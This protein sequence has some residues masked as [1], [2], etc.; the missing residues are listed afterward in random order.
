MQGSRVLSEP[1]NVRQAADLPESR[2]LKSEMR[3]AR[4]ESW[5]ALGPLTLLLI[6]PAIFI[7]ACSTTPV[8]PPTANQVVLIWLKHPQRAGDRVRL[9][10][11]AH[12]LRMIPGVLRVEAGRTVPPLG[13]RAHQDFD[14]GV[15]ITFRDRAALQRYEKDPHHVEAMR[16]YLKPLVRHYEVYN[17]GNR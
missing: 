3:L 10:R 8:P 4:K 15:V 12:S 1:E 14:L 13:P 17:L 16:R 6:C 5:A 11:M 2:E 9:V 7:A